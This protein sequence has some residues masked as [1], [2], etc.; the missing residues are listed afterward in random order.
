MAAVE[1]VGVALATDVRHVA[2]A[3]PHAL[4][5]V[6]GEPTGGPVISASGGVTARS[7]GP[8]AKS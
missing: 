8:L 4:A 5:V 3:P 6:Q 1:P 7:R 2:P